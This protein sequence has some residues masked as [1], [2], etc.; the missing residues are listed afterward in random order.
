MI[1]SPSTVLQQ[2]R[3]A[4]GLEH[5][6]T[7]DADL[8]ERFV[9]QR[10]E[11]AFEALVRRHGPMVLG[12]CRRLLRE[13]QDIEDAFQATFLVFVCKAA[14]IRRRERLG[15][16]LYGV[17]YRTALKAR[18]LL[19]RRRERA[20]EGV[21]M[22]ATD[23]ADE[24]VQRELRT[25]LDAE[26]M[27]L[28]EKYRVPV[29]L[30]YLEGKSKEEAAQELGWP[31]GTVSSRLARALDLLRKRLGQRGLAL[32]A[33]TLGGLLT[34]EASAALP[35]SLVSATVQAG[36]HLFASRVLASGIISS[37][38]IALTQGVLSAMFLNKLK[39]AAVVML[40]LV[41]AAATGLLTYGGGRDLPEVRIEP[42][43]QQAQA[44]PEEKAK[45]ALETRPLSVSGKVSDKDG[46]PI[47][48]A[49]IY[50]LAL[51]G[52]VFSIGPRGQVE[53]GQNEL[54][55]TATTDEQGRYT[56]RETKLPVVPN[57]ADRPMMAI[58]QVLGTAS[59]YA[60]SWDSRKFSDEARPA[61][62]P[63]VEA[64]PASQDNV[65]YLNEVVPIDL[66]FHP[67]TQIQ[68]RIVDEAGKPMQQVKV[69]ILRVVSLTDHQPRT[70]SV[71]RA[72]GETTL[73][74]ESVRAVFSNK[75]GRFQLKDIPA[76]AMAILLVEYPN[77]APVYVNASSVQEPIPESKQQ[78]FEE[79]RKLWRFTTGDLSLTLAASR[80]VTLRAVSSDAKPVA[81][82]QIFINRIK[83]PPNIFASG[84]TDNE[85]HLTFSLPPGEYEV[86]ATTPKRTDLIPTIQT[87]TIAKEPAEQ[88]AEVRIKKGCVVILEVVDEV[89]RKGVPDVSFLGE[90]VG[91]NGSITNT[92]P[93][94]MGSLLHA[95]T[96]A[97]GKVRA[98]LPPGKW[99]FNVNRSRPVPGYWTNSQG[100]DPARESRQG[101][102]IELTEGQTQTLQFEVRKPR[103]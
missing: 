87:V 29:V 72:A 41:M 8:L 44:K 88:G 46:K 74:P 22:P 79:K 65:A 54:V 92:H 62:P 95:V 55:A 96:D 50:L 61:V 21:D 24:V 83:Q 1:A 98:F 71:G 64:N 34:Q 6:A 33:A 48:G 32:T 35:A 89:T 94:S 47:K 9:A 69:N 101:P 59:G 80:K 27:R 30:C 73:L 10:D 19:A 60:L 26:V 75:D 86:D 31:H 39:I 25:L 84:Q 11:S 45:P 81:N 2:L 42:E 97:N 3:K 5:T 58:F 57:Q 43:P 56:F 93:I 100:F 17:A 82:V 12:V 52:G 37:S 103:E 7:A 67:A 78:Y 49:T 90:N 40:T 14:S 91:P 70:P 18:T 4:L 51:N 102:S 66:T 28:P 76:D 53:H 68:G 77:Y 36:L 85:G 99:R 63:G 20:R 38:V 15:P 16:W 13:T 23:V